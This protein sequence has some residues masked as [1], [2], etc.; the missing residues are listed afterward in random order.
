MEVQG[1]FAAAHAAAEAEKVSIELVKAEGWKGNFNQQFQVA[2]EA[3]A[4]LADIHGKFQRVAAE[5]M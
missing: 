3:L 1:A 4:A 5:V 2:T